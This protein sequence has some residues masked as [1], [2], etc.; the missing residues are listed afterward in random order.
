MSSD[1]AVTSLRR[2]LLRRL[3]APLSMLALMSGLIAYW[4]AWQYTQHVIDRSLAD[5]A[6][7]ISKQIQIAG[8]D[9]PFTVPPLAQAM[10]SDPAEALIYRISDGEQE[11][12]GDPKLP[13]QG[14]NVRRMHYAYVFEAEY[15]NRAVRVAQVRV[16]EVDGGKPMVVEVAQPV[17]HRY[18]IAAEFLVAI[19]MPLLLLLL[20]GWGIVWRVVNQQLG[21]LTHLA[22]SLNRQTHT[23]LEPVDET[24]VPLEIRP[25]TS[26]MNALLGRL[27]TALDA[28][29]KFIADAAH[30]LR[31]PLTAVKLHAEQAAIARDPQQTFTAVRELRAAADRAVR[32]S[33][34][35]LSLARAEPGEQAARFV[36]V[37][38]AAMAFE[39]GA[40]WVPRALA[41]HVDLGFQR[42]DEPRDDDQTLLVRGNPVLLREV[43]ANLL[44]NALKYVPLARPHGARITVNVGRATLDAGTPAAEIVVEDNGP[45][46]PASQQA[47]LFKRFFRGDAQSGSGVETGAGLGLAIVH[48]IIVMHGGSVSYADA[49]EGGSR[50][51]VKVPLAAHAAQPASD[52]APA[53]AQMH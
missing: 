3:A 5:L 9:A 39:T 29:R 44:D 43:I 38:L 16:E 22:D 2:S 52:A 28:Q 40:E 23:S 35:L 25:L 15:D 13:L 53:A 4:L 30:Q 1:P 37:D 7:A 14:T 33:N 24:D 51:V 32:L 21:P 18:R 31:T 34:Q 49:P 6:T 17:R 41:A 19:M 27:K 11:L 45:G 50:F 47:D 8:P 36:D 26:A 10:F 48:D 12:A 42:S 20:A 46:V